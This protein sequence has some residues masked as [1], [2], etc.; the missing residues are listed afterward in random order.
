MS[1]KLPRI[2]GHSITV[3]LEPVK[4]GRIH[5]GRHRGECSCGWSAE[6]VRVLWA[7]A[8]QEA[9]EHLDAIERSLANQLTFNLWGH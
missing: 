9:T 6:N 2:V 3:E 1:D 7:A 8:Y 5:E 4:V